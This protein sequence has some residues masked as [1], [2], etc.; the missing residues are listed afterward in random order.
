MLS[1]AGLI[2]MVILM[3]NAQDGGYFN[4]KSPYLTTLPFMVVFLG[5]LCPLVHC[6]ARLCCAVKILCG[7]KRAQRKVQMQIQER[8]GDVTITTDA[9]AQIARTTSAIPTVS[10]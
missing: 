2:I 7:H 4:G 9:V 1:L 10:A 3:A 8:A 5:L 6:T